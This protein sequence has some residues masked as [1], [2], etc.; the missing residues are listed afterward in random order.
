LT[1]VC[2]KKKRKGGGC[3]KGEETEKAKQLAADLGASHKE[4][5][6]PPEEVDVQ[7]KRRERT[8][9]QHAQRKG[10]CA[11]K[12]KICRGVGRRMKKKKGS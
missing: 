7:T 12:R 6:K 8:T 4:E 10:K 11:K 5:G 9:L 2:E 3:P 1:R